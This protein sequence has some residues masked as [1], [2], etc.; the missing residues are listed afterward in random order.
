M[1]GVDRPVTPP[2]DEHPGLPAPVGPMAITRR[3]FLELSLAGATALTVG[4][5]IA[6]AAERVAAAEAS[7]TISDTQWET[8]L[9]VC[10]AFVGDDPDFPKPAS[11]AKMRPLLEDQLSHMVAADRDQFL[12]LLTLMQYSTLPYKFSRLSKLPVAERQDALVGW[13]DS[14]ITLRRQAY[15]ALKMT[16]SVVYFAADET[17]KPI[18]YEGP[19]LELARIPALD[20]PPLSY[21]PGD[22]AKA[23]TM[24]QLAKGRKS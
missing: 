4:R 10:E 20:P 13:R 17:W 14:S 21:Y 18:G 16:T 11:I 9:A 7:F 19:W 23:P 2:L 1:S 8:F 6:V 12:Q 22:K 3:R 5:H 15:T 24:A